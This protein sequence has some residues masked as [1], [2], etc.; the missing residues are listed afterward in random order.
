MGTTTYGY[1]RAYGAVGVR[2]ARDDKGERQH[3]NT[4]QV[5]RS[6][7]LQP[8]AAGVKHQES[9]GKASPGDEHDSVVAEID[10]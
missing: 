2:A 7:V 10:L 3:A 8:H 4:R 9:G 6:D 1:S 5:F